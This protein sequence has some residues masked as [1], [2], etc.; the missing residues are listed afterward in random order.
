[1]RQAIGI[2]MGIGIAAGTA[3]ALEG[4]D[5]MAV[6]YRSLATP[7]GKSC[8]SMHDCAPAEARMQHGRWEVL[9]F[10]HDAD[11]A[12][13]FAVPEGAV[14]LRKNPDGR[15]ILCCTPNGYIRC[16]VPPPGS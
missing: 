10:P 4:S 16:F 2:G 15:P 8:C 12:R 5:S 7:D 13:W 14:L 11:S 9:I 1:V 6:W 3:L